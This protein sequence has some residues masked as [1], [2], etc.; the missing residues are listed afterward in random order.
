MA[1]VCADNRLG[2]LN[3]IHRHIGGTDTGRVVQLADT[4][5]VVVA[6]ALVGGCGVVPG[7]VAVAYGD[8]VVEDHL[9]GALVAAHLRHTPYR[10]DW[11]SGF[12]IVQVVQD[13][14]EVR[15][16]LAAGDVHLFLGGAAVVPVVPAALLLQRLSHLH[17]VDAQIIDARIIAV[18]GIEV[19]AVVVPF[20]VVV[21]GIAG[22]E[23]DAQRGESEIGADRLDFGILWIIKIQCQVEVALL[24]NLGDVGGG[25]GSQAV[26][27]L[28]TVGL[29]PGGEVFAVVRVGHA[30]VEP[31]IVSVSNRIIP[32]RPCRRPRG[33]Q[34]EKQRE[35]MQYMS[36]HNNGLINFCKL[37]WR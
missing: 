7:I 23:P 4:H 28:P 12:G 13:K 5:V 8:V 31:V 21:A 18:R 20:L 26:D 36:F 27:A 16:F 24:H 35:N 2:M 9:L 10:R 11:G 33:Q 3:D 37:Q 22:A 1:R 25:M 34:Q 32:L 6:D 15:G 30:A 29:V 14:P 17:L 19:V